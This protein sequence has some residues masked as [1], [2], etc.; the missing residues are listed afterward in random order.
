MANKLEPKIEGTSGACNVCKMNVTWVKKTWQGKDSLTLRNS[1]DQNAHNVKDGNGG[2]TCSTGSTGV[3][4]FGQSVASKAI[5][6][7]VVW[8]GMEKLTADQKQL[9]DGLR[10]TR[11]I[12]YDFTKECHP[13]LSENSNSFGQINNANM[14]H[15]L[16]LMKIKAI[17]DSK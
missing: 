16:D 10:V 12:A 17:K 6:N 3:D 8:E 1:S 5:E 13:S 9:S 7:Q 11:S 2:W 14:T 15:L 4:G